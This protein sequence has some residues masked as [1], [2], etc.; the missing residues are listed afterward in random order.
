MTGVDSQLAN[1]ANLLNNFMAGGAAAATAQTASDAVHTA[2]A[3][4]DANIDPVDT[5]FNTHPALNQNLGAQGV[6]PL[7]GHVPVTPAGPTA[8]PV[9]H[10]LTARARHVTTGHI[11]ST[12]APAPA[13][14]P[15]RAPTTRL[16]PTQLPQ[17]SL[18]FAPFHQPAHSTHW[19]H[20]P[21]L[22]DLEGDNALTRRVA[23]AL[24]EVATPF[25]ADPGKHATFPH[26]TV[27]R[28]LKKQK[29]NLGELSSTFGG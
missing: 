3:V 7:Q 15:A 5:D 25:T 14:A 13:W 22:H 29:V 24:Q 9:I 6:Q 17:G 2:Q 1:I 21:T 23:E 12:R 8:H 27:T 20:A 4:V 19:G 11:P 10:P 26:H 18:G 16:P 28:G